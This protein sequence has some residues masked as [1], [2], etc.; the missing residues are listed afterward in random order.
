MGKAL[1]LSGMIPLP[2]VI[3]FRVFISAILNPL[4]SWGVATG[5]RGL[6][7]WMVRTVLHTL[8]I[9]LQ[10]VGSGSHKGYRRVFKLGYRVGYLTS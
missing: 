3:M 5:P 8:I 1:S 6:F 4:A 2:T 9:V 7:P 10:R